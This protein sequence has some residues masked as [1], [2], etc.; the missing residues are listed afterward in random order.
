M[1]GASS[2]KS[3][4]GQDDQAHRTRI[5]PEEFTAVPNPLIDWCMHAWSGSEVKVALY[6]ARRTL[7]TLKARANGGWDQISLSQICDGIVSRKGV[8]LDF[9]TGLGRQAAITAIRRLER[10]RA[11]ERKPG[12]G[13]TADSYRIAPQLL[14][15]QRQPMEPTSERYENQTTTSTEIRPQSGMQIAPHR[16]TKI[17]PLEVRKSDRQNKPSSSEKNEKKVEEQ[18]HKKVSSNGTVAASAPDESRNSATHSPRACDQE[19]RAVAP[20]M[21][22]NPRDEVRAIYLQK[23]GTTISPEVLGR[24]FEMIEIREVPI[25]EAIGELRRH[26]PNIWRN[27]DGFLIDFA[28]KIKTKMPETVVPRAVTPETRA[29]N[30]PCPKCR[31]G[32]RVLE[33]IEGQRPRQTDQYCDCPMAK[34]VQ[35]ADRSI[36][37]KRAVP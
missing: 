37:A 10:K 16:S 20:Q 17:E 24:F 7:G 23:T 12:N 30:Q 31:G 34:S 15:K 28:K 6:I 13:R 21:Y 18:T 29:E 27:P 35:A 22:L 9:G 14:T 36:A 4:D 1:S 11:I 33:L 19:T 5:I 8:R 32:G 2:L 26:V 25:P 3:S